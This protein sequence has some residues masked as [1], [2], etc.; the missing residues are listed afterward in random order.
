MKKYPTDRIRNIALC[1]HGGAGKT[2]L[3]EAMLFDAG[4]IDRLGRVDEGTTT[5]DYDPEETKRKVSINIGVAPLEWK[6]HKVNLLDTPGYF[7]FVGEVKSALRVTDAVAIL[8]DAVAGVE[9][10]T[11]LAWHFADEQ[12]LPRMVV[13]NKM[14]RENADFF[15]ALDELREVFG[16]HVVAL[17]VPI[18]SQAG[19]QGA[20]DLIAMKAHLSA[21]GTQKKVDVTEV[22]PD[23]A[24]L[25]QEMRDRLI[26]AAAEADDEL[27]LKYLE[28]QPFT[29]AEVA[30]G[31]AQGIASGKVS[32]V[33]CASG[34]KNIGV[35]LL[36]DAITAYLPSPADRG[37]AQGT[38]PRTGEAVSRKPADDQ[39][40]SALVFKTMADPYVG[41][42]TLFK[43]MS[44]SLK[45]DSH[46]YN[47][48]KGRDERIGQLFAPKG[49]VQ[50]PVAVV[51]AGDIA[52]VAKLQETATGDTLCEEANPAVYEPIKF[53]PPVYS[54]AI[55]PKAKG[56]EEKISSGL[57]RLM[58][59]DPTFK[60]ERNSATSQTIVSGM[61][62]LHLDVVSDRLKRKF[63]VETS[64]ETP[65]VPYRETIRSSAKKQG[66]HKKQTG[67]RGQFGDVW[68]E[69]EPLEDSKDFEFVDKIFGGSV[70]LQY[71]PAVEKGVR[72][73]L[74]EG[75]VA[76]YPVTGVKVTLYDGSYHPVDSSEMAFKIAA[77]LAFK[78]AFMEARPVLLEPIAAVEVTVPD[79][80]MGDV[81]GDLNKKRGKILGM[82]PQG[83]SQVV[84]AL[85]PLGEMFKYAIDLRSLTQG[86]GTYS[87]AVDHYEEVPAHLA[88]HVIEA[89]QKEKAG[90]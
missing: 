58:E 41:K 6:G 77:H 47:A 87:M 50:E 48:N 80:Y 26:E 83:R 28:G 76:G 39:P 78:G 60:A 64:L 37:P 66:R 82:E 43:V 25:V 52:A 49:K 69:L 4:A 5:L 21:G 7:D 12:S 68:L 27:T 81:I 61:G 51:A 75:V 34:L 33:V 29:E 90:E 13:V 63:G 46:A 35:P 56:D 18:G 86:R 2:S 73:I 23:L 45:S 44:G 88:Q 89:A 74:S 54:M 14:D 53:P 57:H 36:L 19:F 8:V 3:A 79:Q 59:E 9:V 1:S 40:F 67:G 32:P 84:R 72:E 71:R 10:G 42:L 55:A 15:K 17:Q 11:E 62:D 24:D 30:R 38:H 85:V 20:V 65:R 22:P 70:P 16:N 31:L